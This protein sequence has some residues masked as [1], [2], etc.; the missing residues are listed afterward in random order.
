MRVSSIF[1]IMMNAYG[2]LYFTTFDR[3]TDLQI[4][5][6]SAGYVTTSGPLQNAILLI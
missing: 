4:V 6:S 5:S 3:L 2:G 1:S